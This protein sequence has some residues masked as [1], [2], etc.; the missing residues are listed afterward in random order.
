MGELEAPRRYGSPEEKFTAVPDEFMRTNVVLFEYGQGFLLKYARTVAAIGSRIA[1]TN[2]ISNMKLLMAKHKSKLSFYLQKSTTIAKD[3]Q[4]IYCLVP[5]LGLLA[6]EE[7]KTLFQNG[8]TPLD[9]ADQ[10]ADLLIEENGRAATIR[11]N[12]VPYN[13]GDP[14][15]VISERS[16]IDAD[17][18]DNVGGDVIDPEVTNFVFTDAMNGCA[19]AITAVEGS[20]VKF[21]AW[22]FQS[23][24]DNFKQGSHFRATKAIRDWFGVNDYYIEDGSTNLAATNII[25]NKGDGNWKMLSQK[26]IVPIGEQVYTIFRE[27][28]SH[29]LNTSADISE[30]RLDEIHGKL[31]TGMRK[32]VKQVDADKINED[33][34]NLSLTSTIQTIHGYINAFLTTDKGMTADQL[35]IINKIAE[36]FSKSIDG[37]GYTTQYPKDMTEFDTLGNFKTGLSTLSKPNKFFGVTYDEAKT[38]TFKTGFVNEIQ[39]AFRLATSQAADLNSTSVTIDP[40]ESNEEL[41]RKVLLVKYYMDLFSDYKS[42]WNLV[43][44][45]DGKLISFMS[46]KKAIKLKTAILKSEK[47][48]LF[49]PIVVV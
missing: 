44:D 17:R 27:S 45:L 41:H 26:N 11:A 1:Q 21:E 39:A 36:R 35:A 25:W 19:Y 14:N 33:L 32:K 6:K 18:W 15:V 47:E 8:D 3:S 4:D 22:H 42:S 29:D 12:Y 28:T 24:S 43:S 34:R 23:E 5:A 2:L 46:K 38:L 49:P 37:G 48:K 30:D 9:D 40:T 13:I 20:S 16:R 7:I 31:L 10:L